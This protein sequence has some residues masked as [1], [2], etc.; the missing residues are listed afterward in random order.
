MSRRYI[1]TRESHLE[2]LQVLLDKYLALIKKHI[3][4]VSNELT[5]HINESGFSDWKERKSKPVGIPTGIRNSTAQRLVD[6]EI[7]H[8]TLICRITADDNAYYPFLISFD[9][10]GCQVFDQG[11]RE[12][13][14]LR[15][16]I[17]PF[18]YANAGIF[19]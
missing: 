5:F 14:D 4:L 9:R 11:I 13:F 18:P 19:N 8:Q 1:T 16:K 17:T 10:A 3:P 15:I 12:G 6:R 2:I 7:R